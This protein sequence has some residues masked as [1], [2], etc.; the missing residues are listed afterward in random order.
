[1]TD[2][3]LRVAGFFALLALIFFL[4]IQSV[5]SLADARIKAKSANLTNVI[6]FHATAEIKA[7]PDIA[8]FVVTVREDGKNVEDAQQQMA[9]KANKLIALLQSKSIE[10]DDLQ[11]TNYN[12][13][14]KYIY[15][16][17]PCQSGVCPRQKQV[18]DGY[19]ASQTITIKLHDLNRAGEILSEISA[20]E[21]NDVTGPNF[22]I[23]N[24]DKLKAQAQLDA[25]NKVK[26]EAKSTAKNLGVRLKNIVR[27]YEDQTP[28]F[29]AGAQPMMMRATP[30]GAP[31][32]VP[33][34]LEN[35]EERITAGV[36]ITYEIE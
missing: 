19:S 25:I 27:F 28:P 14:P 24:H 17:E 29:F 23:E 12:T 26:A 18:I 5:V 6:T 36:S 21:I 35:G 9:Q 34:P 11:T 13:T 7:K 20:L 1:M 16:A 10:K 3:N 30:A 15:H 22:E 32:L 8:T 2:Q 31:A 33:A 4:V